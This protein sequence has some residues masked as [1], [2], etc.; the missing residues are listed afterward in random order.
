M[1][2]GYAVILPPNETVWRGDDFAQPVTDEDG[3]EER[4]RQ[5]LMNAFANTVVGEVFTAIDPNDAWQFWQIAEK[6]G[7]HIRIFDSLPIVLAKPARDLQ[8]V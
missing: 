7:F 4:A 8:R 5:N 2:K 3:S 6:N 1:I